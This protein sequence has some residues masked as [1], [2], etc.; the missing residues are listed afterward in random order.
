MENKP[1]TIKQGFE[2]FEEKTSWLSRYY[3]PIQ[4]DPDT[5]ARRDESADIVEM[6]K[7][8]EILELSK[9]HFKEMFLSLANERIESLR[10]RMK[11]IPED[12]MY[13]GCDGE[14]FSDCKRSFNSALSEE[15]C[16]WEKFIN[17]L[18]LTT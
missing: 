10:G 7:E 11:E 8:K 15:I 1:S 2:E 16:Y 5:Y 12:Y 13:C 4:V 6:L 9:S 14:C 17:T 3:R 18:D